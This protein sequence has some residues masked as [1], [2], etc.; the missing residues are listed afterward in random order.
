V[1]L[2]P[3]I[4]LPNTVPVTHSVAASIFTSDEAFHGKEKAS[5]SA[6]KT[7]R[8]K[9]HAKNLQAKEDSK[10]E[11]GD[12]EN[13]EKSSHR[14][15]ER[16][17]H[18][19][20][21]V[22]SRDVSRSGTDS[23]HSKEDQFLVRV[24]ASL[25]LEQD[26]LV[27]M[28][29]PAVAHC[30][31][32]PPKIIKHRPA[33]RELSSEQQQR[34][35]GGEL[36]EENC[37]ALLVSSVLV[38]DRLELILIR[39]HQELFDAE[40]NGRLSIVLQA[41][42]QFQIVMIK[43]FRVQERSEAVLM[44]AVANDLRTAAALKRQRA[45]IT[46][47]RDLSLVIQNHTAAE[48]ARTALW[49]AKRE[50]DRTRLAEQRVIVEAHRRDAAQALAEEKRIVVAALKERRHPKFIPPIV[51]RSPLRCDSDTQDAF[52][53]VGVSVPTVV[54]PIKLTQK[55]ASPAHATAAPALLLGLQSPSP[56]QS[57]GQSPT[58][59]LPSFHEA[60]LMPLWLSADLPQLAQEK[61]QM[62]AQ[63]EEILRAK[64]LDLASRRPHTD[65]EKSAEK[66]AKDM[67]K[68]FRFRKK[69][70]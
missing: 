63:A 51:G 16:D 57:C 55:D 33:G 25:A 66:V 3:L 43:L 27:S 47:Q 30:K 23:Q 36:S 58:L 42:K 6:S 68:L 69:S 22:L 32:R 62:V 49:R 70:R 7:T 59:G 67:T 44:T 20:R 8:H 50:A 1:P 40:S 34:Q 17:S 46:E 61:L 48:D 65:S 39:R 10:Q 9:Q 28:D 5:S 31:F 37:R 38:Q 15:E 21:T 19:S 11:K 14:E 4:D 52:S 29:Q 41:E 18:P 64:R 56:L 24:G 53:P 35:E 2:Q 12:Q 45:V 54:S 13:V 60:K 26:S